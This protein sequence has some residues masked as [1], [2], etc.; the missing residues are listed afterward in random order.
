MYLDAI[1]WLGAKAPA[2][3]VLRIQYVW[4]SVKSLINIKRQEREQE[5]GN[6]RSTEASALKIIPSLF[7]LYKYIVPEP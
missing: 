7:W 6:G 4:V 2:M 3:L 1:N 5:S